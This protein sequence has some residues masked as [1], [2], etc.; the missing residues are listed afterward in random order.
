MKIVPPSVSIVH[1]KSAIEIYKSIEDA[2]KVC[3]QTNNRISK[4][5]YIQFIKFIIK[6]NHLSVLEHETIS[7]MLKVDRGILAEITRHRIGVGYSVSS[8]RYINYKDPTS[9]E[10]IDPIFFK[11][12]TAAYN[13][14]LNHMKEAEENYNALLML[15]H[16]PQEAR[17]TLPMSFACN[18]RMTANIRAWRYIL[19]LRTT[20][21]A[22][23]QMREIMC[24][25]LQ[26]FKETYPLLFEDLQLEQ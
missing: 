23:P 21:A 7:V 17:S 15:G 3:Y 22:H 16:K 5:S 18:I 11:E 2:A 13:I 12:G 10:V 8:S 9:F 25:T 6:E 19:K 20:T 24:M 14:W 1:T 26:L 4:D